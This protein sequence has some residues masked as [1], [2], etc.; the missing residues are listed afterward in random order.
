[1]F[2]LCQAGAANI[3][4]ESQTHKGYS[5]SYFV[6]AD[7]IT[8][9]GH[10]YRLCNTAQ[11]GALGEGRTGCCVWLEEQ[12]S[13]EEQE[14]LGVAIPSSMAICIYILQSVHDP[15]LVY[16]VGVDYES[17]GPAAGC[18]KK[19]FVVPWAT[20]N[21]V[22][23]R[24]KHKRPWKRMSRADFTACVNIVNN[25]PNSI[26]CTLCPEFAMHDE[27]SDDPDWKPE[28]HKQVQI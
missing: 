27:M 13:M 9:F 25:Q 4:W 3:F 21:R 14:E 11:F 10:T 8:I 2:T 20:M 16:V 22:E 28:A 1:M 26:D 5:L 17:L 18:E 15:E 6:A 12:F 24:S 23:D 19:V 7:R